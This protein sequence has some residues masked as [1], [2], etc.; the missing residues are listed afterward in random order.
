L[1]AR[2]YLR[3]ASMMLND[4]DAGRALVRRPIGQLATRWEEVLREENVEA[5]VWRL[6]KERVQLHLLLR[7]PDAYE[8]VTLG[9]AARTMLDEMREWFRTA[10]STIGLY[11]AIAA[12]PSKQFDTIVLMYV[13]GYSSAKTASIMGIAPDT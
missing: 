4:P 3:Y 5:F 11:R 7:S 6:L 8:T 1:Y 12:L 13:L 10:K 2:D 9:L